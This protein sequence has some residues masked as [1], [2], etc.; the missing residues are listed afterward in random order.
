MNKAFVVIILIIAGIVAG[1][2]STPNGI[3]SD[4]DM[5]DILYD[6]YKAKAMGENLPSDQQYKARLYVESV[7]RKYG[8]TEAEFDSSLVWYTSHPD[9]F[10]K[11][12][13]KL[14]E[15]LSDELKEKGSQGNMLLGNIAGLQGDT[16]EL[17]RGSQ[18]CLLSSAVFSQKMNFYLPADTSF[19]QDD[20]FAWTFIVHVSGTGGGDLA[21]SLCIRYEN[22]S[23]SGTT[24]RIYSSGPV[25][26]NLNAAPNLKPKA[27]YGFIY[28]GSGMNMNNSG[29][30]S[31]VL[32]D[33]FSLLRQHK[34]QTGR[35]SGTPSGNVKGVLSR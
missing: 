8:T 10:I 33:H 13:K 31:I 25:S 28:K 32:V 35:P 3:Y 27:I 17:W 23:I 14:D 29:S 9:D 5:E 22:D 21:A 20:R 34:Q 19:H 4:G 12:Y 18:F 7:F 11:I 16:T 2:S 6:Y 30:P 26:L 1:C 15:R 24:Q